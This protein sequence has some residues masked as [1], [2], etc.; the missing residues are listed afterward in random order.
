MKTRL[1]SRK[2]PVDR[3]RAAAR[4]IRFSG[5]GIS[6]LGGG[7][8]IAIVNQL[9]DLQRLDVVYDSA[10]T[11]FDQLAIRGSDFDEV[12][13]AGDEFFD[14]AFTALDGGGANVGRG[15]RY[16]RFPR[17]DLRGPGEW[18]NHQPA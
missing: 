16:T 15:Q 2:K 1:F 14:T 10:L 6:L 5:A 4:L 11:H 8:A 17:A 7:V 3:A 9:G 18:F 13:E 12:F